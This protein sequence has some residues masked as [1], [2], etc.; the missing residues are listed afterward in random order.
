MMLGV[1]LGGSLQASQR[2]PLSQSEC[3]EFYATFHGD[4][5][6]KRDELFNKM[7]RQAIVFAENGRAGCTH[8]HNPG[9]GGQLEPCSRPCDMKQKVFMASEGVHGIIV[10]HCVCTQSAR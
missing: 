1:M 3:A 6:K 9:L 7:F 5:S 10:L 4:D 8:Y 2:P